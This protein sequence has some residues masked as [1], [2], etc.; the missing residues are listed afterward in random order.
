MEGAKPMS[1]SDFLAKNGFFLDE[2]VARP[3]KS[4]LRTEAPAF[5]APRKVDR[6]YNLWIDFHEGHNFSDGVAG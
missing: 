4:T 2:K 6:F 1:L 3:I 5:N